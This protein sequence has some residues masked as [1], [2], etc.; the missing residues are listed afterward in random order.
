MHSG[1]S[2]CFQ[3]GVACLVQEARSVRVLVEDALS[4]CGLIELEVANADRTGT[5]VGRGSVEAVRACYKTGYIVT[6][7]V[8]EL[9][10]IDAEV[11]STR[12]DNAVWLPI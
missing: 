8:V 9:A 10:T 3:P 4:H 7:V 1:C 11:L 6:V 12:C 2:L 5:R